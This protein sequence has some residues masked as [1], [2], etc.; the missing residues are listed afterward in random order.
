MTHVFPIIDKY[1]C[2]RMGIDLTNLTPGRT[3]VVESHRRLCREEGYGYLCALWWL[4]LADGRTAISVPPGASPAVQVISPD[5]QDPQRL[6][7]P[8]LAEALTGPV[9]A[10]LAQ[11]G[12]PAVNRS[13]RDVS[14]A[15]NA[16]LLRRH[17][18]GDCRRL[19]DE[20]IPAAEG[21]SLP[22]HRTGLMEDRV[23][24][25]GV[26]TA[27]AY[28]RRGFA[29]TAVSAVV[30]HIARG[31]G[32]AFYTCRPDNHASIATARSVGFVPYGTSLVLSAPAADLQA[33]HTCSG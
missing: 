1:L 18:C 7:Q 10:A 9:S 30:E 3:L 16:G 24:D 22:T 5:V 8:D 23:A 32:E 11:A 29:K 26:D 12:L 21:L 19:S 4:W 14:F 31:G 33:T 25:L 20:S 2:V 27:E 13:H 28:R 17:T 15:C 6:S